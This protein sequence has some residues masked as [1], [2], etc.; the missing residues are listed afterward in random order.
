MRWFPKYDEAVRRVIQLEQHFI[1]HTYHSLHQ[2]HHPQP[3][4]TIYESAA[5]PSFSS[6]PSSAPLFVPSK[7]A[8]T[9]ATTVTVDDATIDDAVDNDEGD[10]N[11]GTKTTREAEDPLPDVSLAV[12]HMHL[13]TRRT[14]AHRHRPSRLPPHPTDDTAYNPHLGTSRRHR[15]SRASPSRLWRYPRS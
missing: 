2:L 13:R 8:A 4:M 15:R 5:G 12:D 11:V 6:S 1:C 10:D 14:T 7:T 3:I 9:S